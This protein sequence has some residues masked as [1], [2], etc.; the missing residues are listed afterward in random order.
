V[1]VRRV[2]PWVAVLSGVAGAV[3]GFLTRRAGPGLLVAGLLAQGLLLALP[4]PAELIPPRSWIAEVREGVLVAGLSDLAR[5]LPAW[6]G[7]VGGALV[8]FL[9]VLVLFDHRRSRGRAGSR[10]LPTVGGAALA[11]GLG[12]AAFAE[13]ALRAG[14]AAALHSPAGV[15]AVLALAVAWWPAAKRARARW[16][17]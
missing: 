15:V 7:A 6:A 8:A 2:V 5:A 3:V 12:A 11:A 1:A 4:W 13:A 17:T 14:L 16:R 10:D 9:L